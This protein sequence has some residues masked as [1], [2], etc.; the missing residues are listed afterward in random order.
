VV[1][2]CDG[3]SQRSRSR[4]SWL[5]F[6]VTIYFRRSHA[7]TE[8]DTIVLADFANSTGNPIFDD[9]LKQA[10]S[11]QLAQSPFLDILSD[12]KAAETLRLMGR[13]AGDRVT[14]DVAQEI[15]ERTR[16]K[17]VIVGSIS[18]LG[19]QYML[20]VNAIN[21]STGDSLARGQAQAANNDEIL[22]ALGE[23][24][25]NLRLKLGES[26][27][28][29]EK[30]DTS[31]VQATTPS[32]DALKALTLGRKALVDGDFTDSL[33][34]FQRA[35]ALDPN[36]AL[37]YAA[38]SES[39]ANLGEEDL[40]GRGPFTSYRRIQTKSKVADPTF[41]VGRTL[42]YYRI[43]M[44]RAD[45]ELVVIGTCEEL[46]H[47]KMLAEVLNANWPHEYVIQDFEGNDVGLDMPLGRQEDFLKPTSQPGDCETVLGM[48]THIKRIR[49]P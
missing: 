44:K 42:V 29:V 19:S 2:I 25:T 3:S 21:Y 8:K 24:S 7:L 48:P 10:L 35:I 17:A 46:E 14:S 12:R 30:F 5:R 37:A 45:G 9:A 49:R 31:L 4:S 15:C 47:A 33:P 1:E 20:S 38:L 22:S 6:L 13:S 18:R 11:I 40:A 41:V 27:N 26:L 28:T 32:L 23:L 39:Y 36:F 16:S 34:A 43:V